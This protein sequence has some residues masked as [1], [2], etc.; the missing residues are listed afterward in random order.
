MFATETSSGAVTTGSTHSRILV[1]IPAYNEAATVEAVIQRVR[2]A[3]PE[4]DLLVVNDGSTDATGE[5]IARSGA[6]VATHLCNLGYARSLQTAIRYARLRDYD[7]VITFDADGQHEPTDIRQL[8]EAFLSGDF[9]LLIGS[10][11]IAGRDYRD[12]PFT[13]RIGMRVFSGV[14][15]TGRRVYDTSSGLKVIARSVFDDL[16]RRPVVDFHAETIIYLVRSGYSVGEHPI[17]VAARQHGQ[18]M[19]TSISV[20]TYPL[21]VLFLAFVSVLD[22]RRSAGSLARR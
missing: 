21:K 6:R 2:A 8:H 17:T 3:V 14:I 10:R 19:Y 18:S 12:V 5:A 11:F 13:R 15:V 4:L 16:I 7:A 20:L 22:A 9:D 1:A